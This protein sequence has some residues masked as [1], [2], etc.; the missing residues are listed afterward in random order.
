MDYTNLTKEELVAKLL[1]GD[2]EIR[3]LHETVNEQQQ[4]LT[5]QQ[6]SYEVEVDGGR[7]SSMHSRASL[8]ADPRCSVNMVNEKGD[9]CPSP[10]AMY[11][12]ELRHKR[13]AA[14]S[15]ASQAPPAY[16]VSFG[17]LVIEGSDSNKVS[18]VPLTSILTKAYKRPDE[19]DADTPVV[20]DGDRGEAGMS[21]GR[22][23]TFSVGDD[24]RSGMSEEPLGRGG[25]VER[26]LGQHRSSWA[27]DESSNEGSPMFD[28]ERQLSEFVLNNETASPATRL[29]LRLGVHLPPSLDPM[30]LSRLESVGH[31]AM[32]THGTLH[33]FKQLY[34]GDAIGG[35]MSPVSSYALSVYQYM[36]RV[37]AEDNKFTHNPADMEGLGR[38]MVNLCKETE[39]VLRSEERHIHVQSPVYVFGDIHGNFRDL[40]YFIKNLVSFGDLRYTPHRFVFLGDYVDRGEFSPE[41]IALL[42]AMKVIAPEKVVLLRGNHEDTLVSGDLGSYGSTSFRSQCR[43]LFGPM[44][45]EEVWKR[46]STTFASLPLTANIDGRIFCTHGGLPRYYGGDDNRLDTLMRTD[47]PRLESFFQVPEDETPEQRA[48]RQ[49]ATDTCWSDPAED[50]SQLDKYG[51][52]SNPRGT[53][54]ILFGSAAVQQFLDRH[55]Y[56]YIFRAHQE[57]SDGLRL[58]KNARV[59]TIF[60]TSAYVGHSNGAGVVLV[61][62]NKIRLI[63]KNAPE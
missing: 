61:A 9:L 45:G 47:F 3:R 43:E 25:S 36:L 50:E 12:E 14:A 55:G 37:F 15:P 51:F 46:A 2:Q 10:S 38:M 30:R 60:S 41:V 53:G 24:Y 4:Q 35:A 59:F 7:G 40:H 16:E 33:L 1:Q 29:G 39:V 11:Y 23:S 58:S 8:Q 44:L 19:R 49:A 5:Q 62:D 52:G 57:K 34:A 63:I 6:L 27:A 48:F 32:V 17:V 18:T 56:E 28:G 31:D 26:E 42:F 21:V 20:A 22:H 13:A 54:V